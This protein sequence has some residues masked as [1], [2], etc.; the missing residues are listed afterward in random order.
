MDW[1]EV[2][3]QDFFK[4]IPPVDVR[5]EWYQCAYCRADLRSGHH[6]PDCNEPVTTSF[7]EVERVCYVLKQMHKNKGLTVLNGGKK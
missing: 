7:S 6:K 1:G 2:L 3:S 5:S 4:P